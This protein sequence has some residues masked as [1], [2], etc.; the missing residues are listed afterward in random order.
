MLIQG[1][2][3]IFDTT[4]WN[5]VCVCVGGWASIGEGQSSWSNRCVAIW[6]RSLSSEWRPTTTRL[7]V[8]SGS[9]VC[10]WGGGSWAPATTLTFPGTDSCSQRSFHPRVPE[11]LFLLMFG[12][13]FF[14]SSFSHVETG[15][16]SFNISS[17]VNLA[18]WGTGMHFKVPFL[19]ACYPVKTLK[20]PLKHWMRLWVLQSHTS[21]G[22]F[23]YKVK[24]F[25]WDGFRQ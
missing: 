20:W 11:E 19:S 5:L 23:K 25:Q 22:S 9:C 4:L 17:S 8:G 1:Y 18:A 16:S 14:S 2:H 10:V 3:V 7:W 12:I 13:W 24:L 6:S 21:V 15:R